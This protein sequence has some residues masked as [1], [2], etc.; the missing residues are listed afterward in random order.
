VCE[1]EGERISPSLIFVGAQVRSSLNTKGGNISKEAT[2]CCAPFEVTTFYVEERNIFVQRKRR[3]SIN[4][5]GFPHYFHHLSFL[6]VHNCVGIFN[7]EGE[8]IERKQQHL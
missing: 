1:R 6:L 7:T 2:L 8:D 4:K 3:Y 5:T